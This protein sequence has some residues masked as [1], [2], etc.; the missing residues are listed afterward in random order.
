MLAESVQW[1]VALRGRAVQRPGG[2]GELVDVVILIDGD[3]AVGGLEFLGH[4][5]QAVVN[6]A[7]QAVAGSQFV[8]VPDWPGM[9][10]YI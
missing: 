7:A 3:G 6:L 5:R 9:P 4:A 8:D 1:V 2:A 10:H